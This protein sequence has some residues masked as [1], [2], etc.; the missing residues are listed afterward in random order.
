MR[1]FADTESELHVGGILS[2]LGH[3]KTEVSDVLIACVQLLYKCVSD[4]Q[5]VS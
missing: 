5:F 3:A 2:W 4:V 1:V